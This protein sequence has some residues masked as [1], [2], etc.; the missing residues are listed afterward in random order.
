MSGEGKGGRREGREGEREGGRKEKEKETSQMP[1][2]SASLRLSF[3]GACLGESLE[4][5]ILSA[6]PE[7][8]DKAEKGL[9]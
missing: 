1:L 4:A 8:T 2:P 9:F 5:T 6:H 7:H 3:S